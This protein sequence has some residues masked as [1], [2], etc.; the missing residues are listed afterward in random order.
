MYPPMLV[1]TMFGAVGDGKLVS[2][3]N[4]TTERK[5]WPAESPRIAGDTGR[6]NR[7]VDGM[8]TLACAVDE[9]GKRFWNGGKSLARREKSGAAGKVWRGGK[10]PA[11]GV[12]SSIRRAGRGVVDTRYFRRTFERP[13]LRSARSRVT[14]SKAAL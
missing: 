1:T 14:R 10:S 6:F 13:T 5:I 11:W 7:R 12:A 8:P 4:V 9:G 3:M 2:Q